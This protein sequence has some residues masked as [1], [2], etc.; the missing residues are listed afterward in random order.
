MVSITFS[1][2]SG[3][4]RVRELY[5]VAGAGAVIVSIVALVMFLSVRYLGIK[6]MAR[7][8]SSWYGLIS[9]CTPLL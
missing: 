5:I 4:D 7:K 2:V 6:K 3:R 1:V 8:A 9:L